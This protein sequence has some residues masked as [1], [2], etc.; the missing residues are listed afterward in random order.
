MS[1][2]GDNLHTEDLTFHTYMSVGDSLHAE[3]P[4]FRRHV[5]TGVNDSRVAGCQ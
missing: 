1:V 5:A 4:T 2:K 3:N